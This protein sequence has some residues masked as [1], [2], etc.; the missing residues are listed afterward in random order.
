MLVA[1]EWK[2]Q[3]DSILNYLISKTQKD[4]ICDQLGPKELD[5]VTPLVL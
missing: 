4:T 1:D 2:D 5:T 3:S